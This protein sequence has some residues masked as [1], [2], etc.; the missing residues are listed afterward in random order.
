MLSYFRA[1]KYPSIQ[2]FPYNRTALS[3]C[4]M[5][6]LF[7]PILSEDCLDI[8]NLTHFQRHYNSRHIRRIKIYEVEG[9][10]CLAISLTKWGSNYRIKV[11]TEEGRWVLISDVARPR[12]ELGLILWSQLGSFVFLLQL[13]PRS[14]WS[15]LSYSIKTWRPRFVQNGVVPL[16]EQNT[17]MVATFTHARTGTHSHV[18][19]T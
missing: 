2:S 15:S 14:H 5:N 13:T 9:I 4:H 16:R 12:E 17:S 1:T 7:G 10:R 6:Q 18:G 8:E 19:R 11:K 3:L